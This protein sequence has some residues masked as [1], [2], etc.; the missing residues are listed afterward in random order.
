M[1][2][3]IEEHP[4]GSGRY[5]LVIS[6]KGHKKK[7]TV[8]SLRRAKE[9]RADVEK[10][11][12]AGELGILA[13]KEEKPFVPTLRQY[14][15]GFQDTKDGYI[16]GWESGLQ[17]TGRAYSTVKGYKSVIINHLIPKFGATLIGEISSRQVSSY[18]KTLFQKGY[19]SNTIRNVK[20]CLSAIMKDAK[21][22]NYITVNPVSDIT[23]KRPKDEQRTRDPRPFT[24]EER[25]IFERLVYDHLPE[26]YAFCLCGTRA[27]LR[28]GELIAL[29]W[30]DIDF[31]RKLIHV[32]R[33]VAQNK[34]TTVKYKASE[35]KVR[36]SDQLIESLKIHKTRC[37]ELTLKYGFK[38][39][40][41]WLFFSSTGAFINYGNFI[42]REWNIFWNKKD[43]ELG[44]RTPH[45]LRHTYATLR[46]M[47]GDPLAEVAK[48]MGHS[49]PRI[50][51]ETYFKWLPSESRSDVNELDSLEAPHRP[52]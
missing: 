49:T 34:L 11:L 46:L 2:V 7:K 9:L 28:V 42:K 1:P 48:E 25:N 37:K 17:L 36:M 15:K 6:Y 22:D 35:R 41:E 30:G 8:G 10:R 14:I 33:N 21:I 26:Y 47:K 23:V 31:H 19:S 52:Q 45:D 51:F 39:M 27:G 5:R 12:L 4:K 43:V 3:W 24:L 32:Q 50:T 13:E 18:V 20:N 44:R 40:P 16:E 29:Q 38:E